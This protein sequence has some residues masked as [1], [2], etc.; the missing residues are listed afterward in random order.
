M[1]GAALG[2]EPDAAETEG[3][4]AP[5]WDN[6]PTVNVEGYGMVGMVVQNLGLGTDLRVYVPPYLQPFYSCRR[7]RATARVRQ[8]TKQDTNTAN[9][10]F[11]R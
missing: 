10:F 9:S 8:D 5:T 6:D 7:C 11:D 3:A 1:S 2:A 4:A